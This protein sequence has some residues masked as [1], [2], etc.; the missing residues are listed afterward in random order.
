MIVASMGVPVV[1][2][3]SGGM[4]ELIKDGVTGTLAKEPTPEELA[5]KI[6]CGVICMPT[7]RDRMRDISLLVDRA[8]RHG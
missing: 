5:A 1:T 2:M 6:N 4:A 3:N 7:D 8:K